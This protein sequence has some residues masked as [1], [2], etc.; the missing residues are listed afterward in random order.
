MRSRV[1]DGG[2][3][4]LTSRPCRAAK[5]AGSEDF[6]AAPASRAPVCASRG[7]PRHVLQLLKPLRMS[8]S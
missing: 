8:P 7:S 3:S 6:G 4:A 2:P 1:G 5:P